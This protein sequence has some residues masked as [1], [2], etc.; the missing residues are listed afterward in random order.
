MS[1]TAMMIICKARLGC[2]SCGAAGLELNRVHLPPPIADA[3]TTMS[4]SFA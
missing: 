1:A 2:L 3:P 4:V